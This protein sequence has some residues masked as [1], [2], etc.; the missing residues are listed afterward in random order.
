M[1]YV[2]TNGAA[3]ISL[4][5][6]NSPLHLDRSPGSKQG[7]VLTLRYV[8]NPL[9]EKLVRFCYSILQEFK[10]KPGGRGGLRVGWDR[11]RE[12]HKCQE[13]LLLRT[14]AVQCLPNPG[15]GLQ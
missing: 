1:K 4:K 5:L 9:E 11:P 14:T 6:V 3:P 7:A 8:P 2:S 10:F 15:W 12:K 13:K